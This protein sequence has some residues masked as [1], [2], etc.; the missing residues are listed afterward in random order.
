MA[1]TAAVAAP[2][3]L[4]IIDISNPNDPAVG[5]AMIDAA[6]RYGFFYVDTKGSEFSAADID[7]TFELVC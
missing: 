1:E 2:I 6:A 4:P 3:Q 5:K 7:R